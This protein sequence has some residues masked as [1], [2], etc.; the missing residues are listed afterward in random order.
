MVPFGGAPTGKVIW[1]TLTRALIAGAPSASQSRELPDYRI[2]SALPHG[3]DVLLD[4][5]VPGQGAGQRTN[6]RPPRRTRSPRTRRRPTGRLRVL[7]AAA[8]FVKPYALLFLPWLA[9]AQGI[10]AARCGARGACGRMDRA[11]HL[12]RQPGPSQIGTGRW[13]KRCSPTCIPREHLVRGDVGQSRIGVGPPA[14]GLAA[15]TTIAGLAV[16]IV[17]WGS[18]GPSQSAGIIIPPLARAG[19]TCCS[20]PLRPSSA[21]SIHSRQPDTNGKSQRHP[22]LLKRASTTRSGADVLSVAQCLS[23]S[24]ITVGAL[25]LAASL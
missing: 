2:V 14:T 8:A 25:L 4:G 19:I 5:Q 18:T 13:W 1:Y 17:L 7:V 16:A 23:L 9:A 15:A 6:E 21:S 22:V 20:S 10:T 24:A 3:G 12:R 11:C